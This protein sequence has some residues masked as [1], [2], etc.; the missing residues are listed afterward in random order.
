MLIKQR[1]RIF[2]LKTPKSLKLIYVESKGL[3]LFSNQI[4]KK[5]EVVI[6]FINTLVNKSL[7]SFESVLVTN[8]KYLDTR[9]LTPEAFINHSCNPNTKLDF[10]PNQKTSCYRAIKNIAKNE[11][12][13]F[14]YNT[15]DWDSKSEAF[16][17]HCGSKTCYGR[18]K[19]LKY[20]TRRQQEKLKPFLLP[21]ILHKL[22]RQNKKIY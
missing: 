19:G 7:A 4:F 20:L 2:N 12:I 21:F 11:E 9:W 5:G 6:S 22:V 1:N 3:G 13:T 10:Q 14:N 18:I 15:T 17:C 8:K 16:E